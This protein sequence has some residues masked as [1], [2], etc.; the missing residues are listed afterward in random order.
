MFT[1]S[2]HIELDV[3]HRVPLHE[4]K[5]RNI[6][7]HRYKVQM[8]ISGPL[9]NA[10]AESGMVKDFG[11]LKDILMEVVH[12]VFDHRLVLQ[13]SDP[14][15]QA[16]V[17]N[18]DMYSDLLKDMVD[19]PMS[20]R[21]LALMHGPE[22]TLIVLMPRPPTAENLARLWGER[23]RSQLP[24]GVML[25]NLTVWETPTS[26]AVYKPDVPMGGA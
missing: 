7:G 3:G 26:I 20:P 23:C 17:Q 16:L 1:I 25:V 18:Q 19:D 14:V 4:S 6:H 5:C 10:G 22:T 12:N 21:G 24:N 9:I 11:F 15:A 13:F 8:T 2:K